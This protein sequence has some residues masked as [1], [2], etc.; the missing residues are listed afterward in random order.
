MKKSNVAEQIFSRRSVPP[1]DAI[2]RYKP[3]PSNSLFN[4][5]AGRTFLI[6]VAFCGVAEGKFLNRSGRC[7]LIR[8]RLPPDVN[9]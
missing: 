5:S 2:S 3:P 1:F 9:E 7:P 6:E 8:P 4:F